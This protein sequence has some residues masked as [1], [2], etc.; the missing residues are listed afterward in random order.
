[1]TKT[2]VILA[3]ATGLGL[4]LAGSVAQAS[5][6]EGAYLGLYG[7]LNTDTNDGAIGGWA[8]Y[9]FPLGGDAVAGLEG[10]GLYVP[11]T[12]D[13]IGSANARLG[14]ALGS[15]ALVFVK[16]GVAMNDA[17]DSA[18]LVGAGGEVAVADGWSV[19]ADVD[20]YSGFGAG[21]AFWMGKAG[22][23]YRF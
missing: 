6:W 23:V 11:N 9:N 4:G 16:G 20:R 15:S 2:K 7:G 17:G 22:V 14:Y 10:E 19:R 1:M 12:G 21:A 3:L 13:F 8:G 18:W 5:D